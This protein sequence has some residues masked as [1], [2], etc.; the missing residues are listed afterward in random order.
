MIKNCLYIKLFVLLLTAFTFSQCTDRD[1]SNFSNPD[2]NTF[3]QQ[4]KSDRYTTTGPSGA[5][6][7]PNFKRQDIPLLLLH[8]KDNTPIKEY[9]VNPLSTFELEYYRLSQCLL[10]T[11]EKVRVGNYPSLTPTLMKKDTITGE[12]N[13]VQNIDDIATAWELYNEWWTEVEQINDSK[14][15]NNYYKHN[16]LSGSLYSWY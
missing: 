16:P 8:A 11:I 2:V 12:Y 14:L 3:V 1:S 7:V 9:P 6:E 13:V 4:I 10:W 15:S 5:V